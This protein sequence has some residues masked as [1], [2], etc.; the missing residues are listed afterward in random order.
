MK[1]GY[2]R[3]S[4]FDQTHALQLDALQAADCDH[5]VTETASGARADRPELQRLLD[6]ARSGDVIVVWRLD[7]L[8]R[9]LRHLIEIAEALQQRGVALRSLCESV[10]T[11]T[12]TGRFLFNVIGA[13][14]EM[15][16]EIVIERTRAGLKAAAD[17]GRKGG[18]PRALDDQKARAA[19][20]LMA[21]GSMSISEIAKH[22]GVSVSTIYRHCPRHPSARAG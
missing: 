14:G 12:T 9:S 6:Q 17:R 19:R 7:R 4:T 18:R 22:L 1:F 3:V 8:C 21:S 16:R 5:I 15:E 11:S 2:A 13:L 20:A 10:D